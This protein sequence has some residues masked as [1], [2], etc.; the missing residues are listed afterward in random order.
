MVKVQAIMDFTYKNYDKIKD[1]QSKDVIEQGKIF[2][3]DIFLIDPE[4]A[5]YLTGNNNLGIIAVN[6]LEIIPETEENKPK[7]KSVKKKE[8]DPNASKESK[9]TDINMVQKGKRT[10]KEAKQ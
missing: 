1:L 8:G 7:R 4:E 9:R 5:L 6:V 10:R 2:D 3:G